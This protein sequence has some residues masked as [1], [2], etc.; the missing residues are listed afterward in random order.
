ME[1]AGGELRDFDLTLPTSDE[2][3]A[4]G[5]AAVFLID[6]DGDRGVAFQRGNT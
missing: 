3:P 6:F 1:F 2:P 4:I 5:F